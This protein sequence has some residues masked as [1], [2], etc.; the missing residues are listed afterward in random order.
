[1]DK[2]IKALQHILVI[3]LCVFVATLIIFCGTAYAASLD[4]AEVTELRIATTD[5]AY[6][7]QPLGDTVEAVSEGDTVYVISTYEYEGHA[8]LTEYVLCNTDSG[9]RWLWGGFTG[10]EPSTPEHSSSGGIKTVTAYCSAC[11]PSGITAS[12]KSLARGRVASNDYPIGT[13]LYVDGYGECV[14][15][16]RMRDGGKVDVYLGD[17]D[18]CSCGSEWGKRRVAVEVIG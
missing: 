9:L 17:R 14:V 7:M 8:G 12:G 3:L 18:V 13:R 6:T 16:D 10:Y 1:M 2:H 5:C 11:D 4:T 15:E